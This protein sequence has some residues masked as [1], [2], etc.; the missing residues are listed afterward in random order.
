[1]G[2]IL[3]DSTPTHF[4]LG[5]PSISWWEKKSTV[6]VYQWSDLKLVFKKAGKSA[7]GLGYGVDLRQDRLFAG[8]YGSKP[9]YTGLLAQA[10]GTKNKLPKLPKTLAGGMVIPGEPLLYIIG[11]EGG[12][13]AFDPV[14]YREVWSMPEAINGAI[15]GTSRDFAWSLGGWDLLLRDAVTGAPLA[16]S[17]FSEDRPYGSLFACVASPDRLFLQHRQQLITVS[18]EDLGDFADTR[19]WKKLPEELGNPAEDL[20]G[21]AG[22][23]FPAYVLHR[24]Q[25][26]AS[27][28][29]AKIE[30]GQLVLTGSGSP[31][32]DLVSLVEVEVTPGW[33]YPV[34]WRDGLAAWA[35]RPLPANATDSTPLRMRHLPHPTLGWFPP[36]LSWPPLA[37]AL[38]DDGTNVFP[39]GN[40]AFAAKNTSRASELGSPV[41]DHPPLRLV[42]TSLGWGVEYARRTGET[43]PAIA[44]FSHD[45]ILWLPVQEESKFSTVIEPLGEGWEKVTIRHTSTNDRLF[46]RLHYP[47]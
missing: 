35:M 24:L 42:H 37:V 30:G 4:A 34:A 33:W 47:E 28:G 12:V 38:P 40:A 15:R 26:G 32:V 46:F 43:E 20:D 18:P 45:L 5:S 6:F 31:V 14:S 1:M 39:G 44:E 10:I 11:R 27:L 2:A 25:P 17:R 7:G 21:I 13:R 23:D 19:R 3:M 29:E 22:P 16:S 41:G 9:Q 36:L 8:I